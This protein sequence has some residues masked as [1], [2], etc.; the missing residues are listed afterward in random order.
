M[1]MQ[2]SHIDEW[3]N[4]AFSLAY[5]LHGNR[6]IAKKIALGAMNKLETASNAQFKR[7]YYTPTGRSDGSKITRNRVSLNDLQLLQRL[8]FVESEAYERE[9]EQAAQVCERQLL[10]FFIKH[11]V[12]IS[13]KRNSFYVTLAVSRIL[14]NYATAD[15]ME[16]YNVVV[17]DPERVHDDYY[18]RSRKGVL[19]KE[20]KA[21]FGELL[22][23]VKVN[24]GEERFDSK[25]AE[26]LAETAYE[27]LRSFT[28]WNTSCALPA[29]FDPFTDIIK[30]FHFDKKDPDEEHRTEVNRIHATL[31]PD[32]FSRLTQALNLS[33]PDDKMEIPKFMMTETEINTDDTDRSGPSS[34]LNADELAQIK[35]ILSAQAASRKAAT[36]GFLRVVADGVQI[37]QVLSSDTAQFELGGEAELIEV[38]SGNDT[39]LATHLLDFDELRSGPQTQSI[40]LEGGQ[41]V[42]FDLAPVLDEFGEVAEVNFG[43]QYTETGWLRRLAMMYEQAKAAVAGSFLPLALKPVSALGLVLLAVLAGWLVFRGLEKAPINVAEQV[44]PIGT[45]V[46]S[47]DPQAPENTVRDHEPPAKDPGSNVLP[48]P[49]LS[50]TSTKQKSERHRTLPRKA[51]VYRV[52][53]DSLIA[54]NDTWNDKTDENGILRVPI[55]GIVQLDRG[56]PVI[57]NRGGNQKHAGRSLSEI[58]HI[59]IDV[60]GD[61][62]L[63]KQIADQIASELAGS[64]PFTITS[65]RE[66]ADAALKIH[67]RHESDVDDPDEKTVT[68]VVRLVNDKLY[69]IYPNRT[70]ISGWKYVGPIKNLPSRIAMDLIKAKK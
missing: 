47:P 10:R 67:V 27:C 7:Y 21:R 22:E 66:L 24:R 2:A 65:D 8:V 70:G 12:R 54:A 34:S 61:R 28:P 60:S 45:D 33:S 41:K 25:A 59:F 53:S 14:H 13:L 42:T 29:K 50:S 68:A 51:N 20:L 52:P 56:Q 36:A 35:Q 40:V 46:V 38:Y 6:E 69:V 43:V 19:M 16:I 17:Q 37:G 11:L 9:Q 64:G 1:T 31:H 4:K 44:P 49:V 58:S 32:C 63:G 18:Y 62:I 57:K 26:H 23:V 55:R 30:P 3:L 15:A 39:L 48:G 5:F